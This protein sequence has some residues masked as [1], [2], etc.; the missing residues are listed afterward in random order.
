MNE[1][2]NE[3]KLVDKDNFSPLFNFE[4]KEIGAHKAPQRTRVS[5]Y[6]EKLSPC[7]RLSTEGYSDVIAMLSRCFQIQPSFP[8]QD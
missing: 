3:D 4:K 1:S 2:K 6:R 8:Q 7:A 5:K